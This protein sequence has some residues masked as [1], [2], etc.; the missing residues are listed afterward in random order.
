MR[1]VM[2]KSMAAAKTHTSMRKRSAAADMTERQTAA[3]ADMTMKSKAAAA[4]M[5]R[6]AAAAGMTM[7]TK[8]QCEKN[9]R[10]FWLRLRCWQRACCRFRV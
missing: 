10:A 9:C 6:E 7:A 1:I 5:K 4:D 3:A 8:V 2:L